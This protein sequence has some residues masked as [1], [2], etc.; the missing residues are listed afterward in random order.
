MITN[1]DDLRRAEF[2]LER[3]YGF[4]A[5]YLGED[6]DLGDIDG[7]R[8][9][10]ICQTE[11]DIA[12]YL[13]RP[14]KRLRFWIY[15]QESIVRLTIRE[16]QTIE[17]HSGGPTDEGYSHHYESYTL[18]DGVLSRLCGSDC[19]D[20][21]GRM[22]HSQRDY[23]LPEFGTVPCNSWNNGEMTELPERRPNW[24]EESAPWQR[25]YAA[26]AAGY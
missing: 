9:R 11:S 21:D 3:W 23:W 10:W 15:W 26:E 18:E 4:S 2:L 8:W 5:R 25:D 7:P 1:D 24:Q 13:S 20:C 6:S 12:Q 16:G 22:V 17:L 14:L 19:R